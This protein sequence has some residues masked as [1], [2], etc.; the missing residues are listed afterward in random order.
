MRCRGAG[1]RS[2]GRQPVPR[3]SYEHSGPRVSKN[4][5]NG[6]GRRLNPEKDKCHRSMAPGVD[7][8]GQRGGER[9]QRE[10]APLGGEQTRVGKS[11]RPSASQR[12]GKVPPGVIGVSRPPEN[13][14]PRVALRSQQHPVLGGALNPGHQDKGVCGVTG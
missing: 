13:G 10:R 2:P 14:T 9:G 3:R 6:S 5:I 1:K 11:R 12:V 8:E 7:G 4:S